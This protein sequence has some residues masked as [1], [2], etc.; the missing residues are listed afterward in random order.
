M[1]RTLGYERA[2]RQRL[3]GTTRFRLR[4]LFKDINKR[5]NNP[6][7]DNYSWYG[8]K[9]I[10][11]YLTFDDLKFLWER[12]DAANMKR[13]SIDRLKSQD[14]Y[15]RDNCRFIEHS[16]N[17]ARARRERGNWSTKLTVEQ[18]IEIRTLNDVDV[19]TIAAQFGIHRSHVY[20]LRRGELWKY[21]DEQE[22]KANGT[23]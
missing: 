19:D 18:V 11:N 16:D 4:Q 22:R 14:N 5:C 10:K 12:D 21:V 8:G 6:K 9:G 2:R 1:T 13:P 23:C 17:C 20:R 15:H 3:K 7:S